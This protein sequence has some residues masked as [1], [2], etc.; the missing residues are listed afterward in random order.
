M[1]FFRAHQQF[2]QHAPQ[3]NEPTKLQT[4]INSM[5]DVDDDSNVSNMMLILDFGFLNLF[6]VVFPINVIYF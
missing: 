3:I 6:T 1:S 5:D 2:Q 4:H